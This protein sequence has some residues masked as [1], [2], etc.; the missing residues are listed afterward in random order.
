MFGKVPTPS[1]PI[2]PIFTA[3]SDDRDAL[4][5]KAIRR[6]VAIR[7]NDDPAG[8]VINLLVYLPRKAGTGQRV[9]AFLGLIFEGNHAVSK[10]PGI[11]LST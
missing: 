4:G 7:F 3:S 6:E 2:K 5:G 10:N 11:A 8:P 9:P 1:H